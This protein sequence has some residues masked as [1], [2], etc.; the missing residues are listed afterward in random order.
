MNYLKRTPRVTFKNNTVPYMTHFFRAAG[1]DENFSEERG[2]EFSKLIPGKYPPFARLSVQ[3][4]PKLINSWGEDTND[5]HTS[6]CGT[7][8]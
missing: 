5:L 4:C 2:G 6:S 8:L 3:A 7:L 1:A